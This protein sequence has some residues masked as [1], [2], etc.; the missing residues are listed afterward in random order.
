MSYV[1]V[2]N[3]TTI[4]I[5]QKSLNLWINIDLKNGVGSYTNLEI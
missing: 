5:Y 3:Y 1:G 2:E 4:F